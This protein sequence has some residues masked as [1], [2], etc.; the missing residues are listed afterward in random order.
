MLKCNVAYV[1]GKHHKTSED[2]YCVLHEEDL[3]VAA[4]A[5]GVGSAKCGGEGSSL[6]VETVAT[7]IVENYPLVDRNELVVK[8]LIRTAYQKALSNIKRQADQAKEDLAEYDTTLM[9]IVY[10]YVTS[11]FYYGHCGDG[12]IIAQQTNGKYVN[13]TPCQ[14]VDQC[15]L[16]LRSGAKY[17]HIDRI[18]QEIVSIIC[19]TDGIMDKIRQP[20]IEDTDGLYV[21]L[22]ML[23]SDSNTI[24]YLKHKGVTLSDL[25]DNPKAI[26]RNLVYTAMFRS[27]RK[28]G[29]NKSVA[30][31]VMGSIKKS[32]GLFLLLDSITDDKTALICST[33]VI[34]SARPPKYYMPP[35][36]QQLFKKRRKLLYATLDAE[37]DQT[38]I[39]D[40]VVTDKSQDAIRESLLKRIKLAFDKLLRKR[41]E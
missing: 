7:F 21:P 40:A 30:Q 20:A 5:D 8:S 2:A 11:T 39:G 16:T 31:N 18:D 14:R 23:L 38:E 1:P 26:S 15:V 24:R 17:W 37:T 12:G 27:L 28:Y 9:V 32:A 19:A 6:A 35:D 33:N 13:L 22:L 25:V 3:F 36:W 4:I 41:N 34:P 10:D 29:L